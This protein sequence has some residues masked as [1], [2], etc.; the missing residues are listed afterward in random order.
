LFRYR[1]SYRAVALDE[2]L[3]RAKS[4]A[5]SLGITRVTDI[6]RLDRL[7]VP[8]FASI[9]PGAAPGSLCVNAG[10]GLSI[11]E[12]RVGAYMESIEFAFAEEKT[13]H[14]KARGAR[15]RDV[16]DGATRPDAILDLCPRLG[17][18]ISLD[19]RLPCVQAEVLGGGSMLVP[20]ELVYFPFHPAANK[21]MFGSDTNGLA[22][23]ATITEATVHGLFEV[24]ERDIASFDFVHHSSSRVSPAS[25]P[26]EH[27]ALIADWARR[28]FEVSVRTMRNEF[29]VAWFH[30]NLWERGQLDPIY[31]CDGYGCHADREIALTRA[32]TEA[33]QS[34]LSFIHGARDDLERR[35][36]L[37]ARWKAA[38][39][40]SYAR[41]LITTFDRGPT[42]D[43]RT[44]PD[45]A[46]GC[47]TL[48]SLLS[49][50]R[51]DLARAGIP[52]V[53]RVELTAPRTA[54]KVVRVIVPLL[55][56]FK[57]D[58]PRVGRRLASHAASA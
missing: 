6:T 23:G 30:V 34:R 44:I 38:R 11:A 58:S 8:V 10:K 41:R 40:R 5:R 56:H 17:L 54:V 12:A 26:H 14:P 7:A 29:G 51:A 57:Q 49:K 22:S 15:A 53:L 45:N 35:Y 55:E 28:G 4:V 48:S 33:T 47:A 13:A 52:R 39:R 18:K 32:L 25:L 2:S 21:T 27:R 9:R 46:V 19:V 16:L 3:A 42:T 24:I 37:F 36:A 43:Y 1:S 20:A 31:V 50:L